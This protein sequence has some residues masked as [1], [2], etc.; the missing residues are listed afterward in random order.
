MLE[1]GKLSL[2]GGYLFLESL[3]IVGFFRSFIL[4]VLIEEIVGYN[5]SMAFALG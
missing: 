1:I 5:G 3:T 2:M 4:L